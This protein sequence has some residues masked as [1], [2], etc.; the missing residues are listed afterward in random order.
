MHNLACD[1]KPFFNILAG[2]D[3]FLGVKFEEH[4]KN[5]IPNLNIILN[6]RTY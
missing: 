5:F 6:I 3:I 2:F 1:E 4:N